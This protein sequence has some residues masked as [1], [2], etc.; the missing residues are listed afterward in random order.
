MCR[1][2]REHLRLNGFDERVPRAS[3]VVQVQRGLSRQGIR[4]FNEPWRQARAARKG[5]ILRLRALSL[6]LLP[7]PALRGE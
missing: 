1:L 2:Y 3:A 7:W 5:G 4:A 6:W